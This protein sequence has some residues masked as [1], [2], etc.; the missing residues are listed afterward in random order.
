MNSTMELDVDHNQSLPS[1]ARAA[2]EPA[3]GNLPPSASPVRGSL[4][5][6]PSG[7]AW[8]RAEFMRRRYAAN[9]YIESAHARAAVMH[10]YVGTEK[11]SGAPLRI[12]YFGGGENL[13]YVLGLIYEQHR[14]E[15]E[16][17]G[18]SVWQ[19]RRWLRAARGQ[20]DL[21]V[22]DLP[23]PYHRLLRGV[24]GL[25][26]PAW[27]DQ[28]LRLPQRWDDVF[29]QLR[30]SAKSVD[31]RKIRR[32]GLTYRVVRD[33]SAIRRFYHE[34]YVPHISQR[35]GGAAFVEPE[36]KI[37]YCIQRG[38]LMQVLAGDEPI[39]AQVMYPQGNRLQFLWAGTHGVA[40]GQHPKAAFPALYYFGVVYAFE[41]GYDDADYCGSRP[42]LADGVLQL[43]RRWGGV[44]HDGWSL[45][46]L[47]FRPFDLEAANLGFLSRC[48]LVVRRGGHLVGKMACGEQAPG[49]EDI[50][51]IAQNYVTP[52]LE[53]V[54]VYSLVTP[55]AEV[56]AAG[57]AAG[58]DIVD[59]SGQ[60]DPATVLSRD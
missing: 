58:C 3:P 13:A 7:M 15:E 20:A 50:E 16:R 47:F 36:W 46:T 17:Q 22:A 30:G 23:W 41:N 42:S 31:L 35:F 51:R 49:L 24:G 4:P 39:A 27:V 60:R 56:V 59:L 44:I 45:E 33:D 43:K 34:M 57:A 12:L 9:D 19:A 11:G 37:E 38:A 2:A 18:L 25:E 10:R 14:V 8:V 55:G 40:A 28:R 1:N 5:E 29:A 52:G 26:A 32:H 54:R 6:G 48:P 53:R 21:F